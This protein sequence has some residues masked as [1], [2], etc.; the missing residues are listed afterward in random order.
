MC[1]F[2]LTLPVSVIPESAVSA[3]L[4]HIDPETRIHSD[5]GSVP[6][7]IIESVDVFEY[8]TIR[9]FVILY[10]ESIQPLPFYQ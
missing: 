2:C 1:L 9:L 10:L 3:T 4:L 8:I 6:Y 5:Y 7:Y